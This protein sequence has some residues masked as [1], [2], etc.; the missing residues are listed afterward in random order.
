MQKTLVKY[1]TNV[2]DTVT[3]A[4]MNEEYD[5][6]VLASHHLPTAVAE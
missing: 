5:D 4:E 1:L 2:S 6:L 3:E